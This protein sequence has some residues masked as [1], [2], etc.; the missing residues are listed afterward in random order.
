MSGT[1]ARKRE[2]EEEG[3]VQQQRPQPDERRGGQIKWHPKVSRPFP[4]FPP[5]TI[6]G[7]GN[8]PSDASSE[9]AVDDGLPDHIG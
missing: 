4:N 7:D 2:K 6:K 9:C 1:A 3:L 5:S 8:A